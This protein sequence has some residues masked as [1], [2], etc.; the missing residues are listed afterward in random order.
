[1]ASEPV[2]PCRQLD[3]MT[4]RGLAA[5]I[6]SY[7][8]PMRAKTPAEKLSMRTSAHRTSCQ[9]TS[10]E[11]GS[12]RSS[13]MP[14]FPA[15]QL[16][17]R[18]LPSSGNS[19]LSGWNGPAVRATSGCVRLSTCTTVAPKSARRRP[20]FGPATDH[21]MSSTRRS[22]SAGRPLASLWPKSTSARGRVRRR[23]VAVSEAWGGSQ[24]SQRR[25]RRHDETARMTEP[26]VRARLLDDVPE[27]T[28][29][30]MVVG[31]HLDGVRDRRQHHAPSRRLGR[32]IR[33]RAGGGEGGDH[34]TQPVDLRWRHSSGSKTMIQLDPRR[35]TRSPRRSRLPPRSTGRGSW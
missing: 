9:T 22:A 31:H 19:V 18:P 21:V 11:A 34:R 20:T 6:R 2:W 1:M 35:V 7:P 33:P 4:M 8:K 25:A 28:R 24:R 5:R 10:C 12:E 15:L 13:S 26:R 17:H 23:A 32:E 27:L 30:Q 29:G 14:S 3:S 16:A